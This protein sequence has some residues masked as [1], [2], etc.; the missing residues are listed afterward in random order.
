MGRRRQLSRAELMAFFINVYNMLVIHATCVL[1]APTNTAAR[2][3]TPP[4]PLPP[5][6]ALSRRARPEAKY[7]TL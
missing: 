4:S 6:R 2:L 3:R 1:G 5:P 7:C